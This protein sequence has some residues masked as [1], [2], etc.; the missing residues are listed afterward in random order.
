[1]P[2]RL[3]DALYNAVP[4]GLGSTGRIR[5][6]SKEIDEVLTKGSR[7]AVN[8][9]YGRKEDLLTTE[10]RGEMPGAE[11][12]RVSQRAKERGT[13]QLGT[14][15]SGN[16]FLEVDIVDEIYEPEI[17]RA[18]GIDRVGQ[19]VL[20]VHCGSRGL[21]HQVADDYIKYMLQAMQKYAHRSAGPPARLRAGRIAGRAGLSRR[22]ALRR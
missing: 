8:S 4:S 3:A 5:L 12:D 21:G 16:H 11:P 18:M 15:G 9:G 1:M 19:A 2:T 13:P 14:L 22:N 10:E 17:A 20:Y 7:W 6:R